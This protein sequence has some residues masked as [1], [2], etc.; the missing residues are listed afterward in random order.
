MIHKILDYKQQQKERKKEQ[1]ECPVKPRL[2]LQ[3]N[4][5]LFI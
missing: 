2:H 1:K 5:I 3:L 4:H